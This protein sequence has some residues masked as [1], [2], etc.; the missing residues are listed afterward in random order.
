VSSTLS[1]LLLTR[2]VH[3]DLSRQD[4]LCM[5]SQ[6][7][8]WMGKWAITS[9][10]MVFFLPKFVEFSWH[11]E[12]MTRTGLNFHIE[13]LCCQLL[14]NLWSI[15]FLSH[16]YKNNNIGKLCFQIHTGKCSG[17]NPRNL[18]PATWNKISINC[19][20]HLWK[21]CSIIIYINFTAVPINFYF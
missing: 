19:L 4:P 2:S 9:W 21:Y 17:E 10:K 5:F 1:I 6:T 3:L 7:K 11:S 12:I 16:L 18:L 15:S 20:Q 8:V 14:Q 13:S